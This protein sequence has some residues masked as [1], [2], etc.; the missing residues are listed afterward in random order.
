METNLQV[1]MKAKATIVNEFEFEPKGIGSDYS[2]NDFRAKIAV[3]VGN[4]IK[5]TTIFIHDEYHYA[6]KDVDG[7]ILKE[8]YHTHTPTLNPKDF[9]HLKMV[10]DIDFSEVIS[11][12]KVAV[13]AERLRMENLKRAE[14]LKRLQAK[15]V[16]YDNSWIHTFESI[17]N[18][19]KNKE[20]KTSLLTGVKFTIPTKENIVSDK[21]GTSILLEYRN[22]KVSI[23]KDGVNDGAYFFNNGKKIEADGITEKYISIA[24]GKQINGKTI[25]NIFLKLIQKINLHYDEIEYKN[26]KTN[27]EEAERKAYIQLLTDATNEV[28]Y[29]IPRWKNNTDY[30][31][32]VKDGGYYEYTYFIDIKEK[33][34]TTSAVSVKVGAVIPKMY[35]TTS[36]K[37]EAMEPVYSIGELSGLSSDKIKAIIAILKQ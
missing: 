34:E 8:S 30:R 25:G 3:Q 2:R 9:E 29:S 35:N 15:G 18:A 33:T 36:G 24:E 31:G 20:I 12:Y 21:I 22:I 14:E 1:A 23:F 7:T 5:N 16:E 27:K 13:E 32:R 4:A 19:D 17:V 11:K 37:Y 6:E 10:V 28:I 26:N